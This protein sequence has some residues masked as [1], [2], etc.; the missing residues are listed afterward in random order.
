MMGWRT[1][2]FSVGARLSAAS[3]ESD[4]HDEHVGI[5]EELDRLVRPGRDRKRPEREVEVAALD[6]LEELALVLR[7]AEHHLDLRMALGEAAQESRDDLRS[8]ALERADAEAAGVA[9]LERAHV[10]LRGEEPRLDRLC[11]PEQDPARL[12]QRDGPRAARALD[13]PHP[14]DALERRDLLRD[15]RLRVAE[16][17]G[18]PPERALVGDRLE[19]D[20]MA[21]IEPEPAISFH[22][23]T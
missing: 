23:R 16:L 15:R 5:V 7:L 14:D 18:G 12:R 8:D 20:E 11:V 13:Q 6:H 2:S 22:D 17:L 10:R 3:G 21:K 19:R 4:G 9:R 1:I